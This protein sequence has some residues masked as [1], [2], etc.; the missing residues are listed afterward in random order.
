VPFNVTLNSG[1]VYQVQ[2]TAG[3][4]TGSRVRGLNVTDK[5]SVIGGSKFPAVPFTGGGTKDPIYEQ[6]FP[7][8]SWGKN[9][10]FIPTPL[11]NDDI[12]RVIASQNGTSVSINGT[13]VATLNAGQFY[14]Q[15]DTIPSFIS[16]NQPISV[17]RY[18]KCAT[19][20]A[21]PVLSP[22]SNQR[23]GDPSM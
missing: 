20:V 17:A 16:A 11:L 22:N 5:F 2:S 9:Y 13:A 12:C 4:L 23:L 18:L 14:E 10:I 1:E 3:D 8:S 15:T 21:H 19:C 7:V 6:L